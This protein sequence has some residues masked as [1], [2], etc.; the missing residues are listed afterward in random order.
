MNFP[1]W[2]IIFLQKVVEDTLEQSKR[3]LE[4]GYSQIAKMDK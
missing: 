4:K 1:S 3:K 2:L